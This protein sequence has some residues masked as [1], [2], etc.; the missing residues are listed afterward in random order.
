M[1]TLLSN[2]I[3]IFFLMDFIGAIPVFILLTKDMG[4]RTRNR[5][6]ILSSLI[7]GL[8]VALFAISGQKL[9]NH[10]GLSIDAL[11]VGGGVIMFYIAFEMIFAG[12]LVYTKSTE[13][14]SIIVSPLAT[15]ML[16]GP[17]CLSFAMISFISTSGMDKA[18]ILISII[19]AAL[20]GMIVFLFA[21]AIGKVLGKEAVRGIEKIV[22]LLLAG[23][24]AEMVMGG[25]KG[26]F[27]K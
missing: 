18:Y 22:A 16:A 21:N 27:I 23:F 14:R 3:T 17:G 26:Y 5:T 10:F 20:A 6:A 4:N 2:A 24:A 8:I 12:Q 1:K 15:P 19:L 11:K 25:I 13:N 9:L 7:A